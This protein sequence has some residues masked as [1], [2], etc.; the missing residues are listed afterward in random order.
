MLCMQTMQRYNLF[1]LGCMTYSITKISYFFGL[2]FFLTPAT[3]CNMSWM[4]ND[5]VSTSAMTEIPAHKPIVP[6]MSEKSRIDVY[7]AS[8]T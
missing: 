8:C 7:A 2:T 5:T 1:I 6:P 3:H 4:M